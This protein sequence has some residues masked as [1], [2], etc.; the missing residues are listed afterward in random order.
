MHITIYL[1]RKTFLT[2]LFKNHRQKSK[3]NFFYDD[4]DAKM[5]HFST[6]VMKVC[7]K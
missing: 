7:K 6:L 3:K 5:A 4:D 1:Y 2:I